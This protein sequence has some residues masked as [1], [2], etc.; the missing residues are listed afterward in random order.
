MNLI[1]NASEALGDRS[2]VITVS[3]GAT[4]CD[5]ESLRKTE[6]HDDLPAGRYVYL[7][8]TDTG[9][10]MDE[11]TRLRIFEPFF[12]TCLLYTSPSPRDRQKSRMPSSA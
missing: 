10:G 12:S 8:V 2:G 7:E 1:I 4:R 5:E 6:L 11:K 3:V 9:I